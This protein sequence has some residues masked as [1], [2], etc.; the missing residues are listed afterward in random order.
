[1]GRVGRLTLAGQILAQ[2]PVVP[3]VGEGIGRAVA[4][5]FYFGG[6]LGYGVY[7]MTDLN[8]MLAGINDEAGHDFFGEEAKSSHNWGV[9]V[10]FSFGERVRLGLGYT[11]LN[12]RAE[13][14]DPSVSI[15]Y[16]LPAHLYQVHATYF[17]AAEWDPCPHGS[18]FVNA[19]YLHANVDEVR[20]DNE[21]VKT[22][23]GDDHA[24]DYSG[25]FVRLGVRLWPR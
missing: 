17:L 18:V 13:Y 11:R 9:E 19:G 22:E 23:A 3:Q 15:R 24:L 21:I 5:E 20:I 10:G 1:M 16:E 7:T 4:R 25:L 2:T 6:H 14:S 12:A 8:D